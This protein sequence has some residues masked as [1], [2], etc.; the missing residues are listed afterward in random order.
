VKI[1]EHTTATGE[2]GATLLRVEERRL[3]IACFEGTFELPDGALPAVMKRYGAPLEPSERVIEV[4]ALDVPEGRLR[5]VRHLAVY[6]V[7][8]RDYLVHDDGEGQATCALAVTVAKALR[9]LAG[10]PPLP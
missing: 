6:D 5:H 1:H 10:A 4:D 9:H 7:I 8:A 3:V 2:L